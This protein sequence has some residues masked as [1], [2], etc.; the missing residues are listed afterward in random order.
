MRNLEYGFGVFKVGF[1]TGDGCLGD[2]E[3]ADDAPGRD[4]ERLTSVLTSIPAALP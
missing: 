3:R 4:C 1:T 2:V